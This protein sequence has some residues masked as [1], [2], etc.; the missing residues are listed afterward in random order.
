LN[1]QEIKEE[2]GNLEILLTWK[3]SFLSQGRAFSLMVKNWIGG[4]FGTILDL[5]NL[6]WVG[7]GFLKKG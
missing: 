7:L 1:Q 2:K 3:R 6:N 4:I 5:V